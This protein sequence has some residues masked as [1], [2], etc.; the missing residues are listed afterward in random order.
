MNIN[1]KCFAKLANDKCDYRRS[2]SYELSEG[3]TI[4]DL[5]QIAGVQESDVKLIFVNSKKAESGTKLSD[6]DQVGLAPAV[7]GM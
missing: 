6:G 7:G 4:N 5:Y 1:L 2:T 3:Q